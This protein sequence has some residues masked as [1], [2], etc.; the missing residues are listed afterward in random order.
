MP[1][2]YVSVQTIDYYFGLSNL[3]MFWYVIHNC[4][5]DVEVL[6]FFVQVAQYAALIQRRLPGKESAI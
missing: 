6:R 5:H 3:H 2:I 1:V 4:E